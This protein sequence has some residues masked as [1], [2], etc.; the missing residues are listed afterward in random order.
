[1]VRVVMALG[2]AVFFQS[3]AAVSQDKRIDSYPQKTVRVIIP[4]AAGGPTDVVARSI[5]QKL[6]EK[7]GQQF[8]LDNRSGAD[9]LLAMTAAATAPADGYTLLLGGTGVLTSNPAL[10]EKLPYDSQ[11]D[12]APIVFISSG[13]FLLVTHP[14]SGVGSVADLVRLANA[15]PR[16]L[17][18]G[19]GGGLSNL[20][21]ISFQFAAGIKTTIVPYK[22]AAPSMTDLI[23]GQITYIFTSTTA[24][25]PNVQAGRLVGLGVTTRKRWPSLP[26]I[27]AIAETVPAFDD[28]VVWYGL[29]AP[30]RTPG[31]IVDKLN[32]EINAILQSRDIAQRF[33]AMG[34]EVAGGAPDLFTNIISREIAMW[35]KL[36][37]DAN[38]KLATP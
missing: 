7:W 17:T 22:G 31:G 6:T 8:L 16:E 29:L 36:A 23:G 38:L 34:S 2:I 9:G 21:G 24:A 27:P 14:K 3:P 20:A 4:Y 35:T 13:P 25:L 33:A 10:H 5:G 30:A 28:I 32:R 11:K 12:Y 18:F 26:D 15:R 1:M 19:S 37:K